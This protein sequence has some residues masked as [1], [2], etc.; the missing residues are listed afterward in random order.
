MFAIFFFLAHHQVIFP[1]LAWAAYWSELELWPLPA[2]FS[3]CTVAGGTGLAG[4]SPAQCSYGL[5]YRVHPDTE[6]FM[7]YCL[8][9]K[10]SASDIHAGFQ[11][12]RMP[13]CDLPRSWPCVQVECCLS[14]GPGSAFAFTSATSL[15]PGSHLG[16]AHCMRTG[17]L[18]SWRDWDPR[19][20]FLSCLF[21]WWH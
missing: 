15:S 5:L 10:K 7:F 16:V 1:G 21:C 8:F 4:C 2:G 17:P 9:P 20:A 12:T 13:G 18:S 3:L 11:A 14:V 19:R 6:G